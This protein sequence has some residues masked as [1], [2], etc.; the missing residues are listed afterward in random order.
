MNKVVCLTEIFSF[1]IFHTQAYISESADENV[2]ELTSI[3]ADKFDHELVPQDLY[4]EAWIP[5]KR[6]NKADSG[7]SLVGDIS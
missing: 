3:Y 4:T 5:D 1:S 6:N 2:S 7:N